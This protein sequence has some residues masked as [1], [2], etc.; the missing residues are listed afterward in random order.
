[1]LELTGLTFVA[2]YFLICSGE[3]TTQVKAIAEYIEREL[4][5]AGMKPRGIEGLDY[6]HWVL[7]DYGDVIIHIFE[8][9]TRDFYDLEKLWM[10]AP[11]V[12]LNENTGHMGGKDKR[13]VHS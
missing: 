5:S 3:S 4:S 12:E 13:A 2:D 1:M 6:S 9:E 7:I 10:D 8:K 11:I